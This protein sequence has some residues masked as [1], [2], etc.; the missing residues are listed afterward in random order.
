MSY[1]YRSYSHACYLFSQMQKNSVKYQRTGGWQLGGHLQPRVERA[2]AAGGGGDR[3]KRV[4]APPHCWQHVCLPGPPRPLR[5]AGHSRARP[6][7]EAPRTNVS[8][9]AWP[10]ALCSLLCRQV[11][12]A[13]ARMARLLQGLTSL[14]GE[15][16]RLVLS[17]GRVDCSIYTR[18]LTPDIRRPNRSVRW[19]RVAAI[20]AALGGTRHGCSHGPVSERRDPFQPAAAVLTLTVLERWDSRSGLSACCSIGNYR[21][22]QPVVCLCLEPAGMAGAT[23]RE[24]H[25]TTGGENRQIRPAHIRDEQ[26]PLVGFSHRYFETFSL[27]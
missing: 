22:L 12:R 18:N 27:V 5:P 6:L 13:E 7:H 2:G 11:H 4:A 20:V 25:R 24:H 3:S 17:A 16:D 26:V 14:Q 8:D 23:Q 15:G 9:T 10:A 19:V 1:V 21:S